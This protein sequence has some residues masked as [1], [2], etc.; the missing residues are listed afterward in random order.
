[1]IYSKIN[2]K[3]ES[4]SCTSCTSCALLFSCC[5]SQE[6]TSSVVSISPKNGSVQTSDDLYTYLKKLRL[7]YGDIILTDDAIEGCNVFFWGKIGILTQIKNPEYN[8]VIVPFLYPSFPCHYFDKIDIYNQV[9]MLFDVV[10]YKSE[11]LKSLRIKDVKDWDENIFYIKSSY[12]YKMKKQHLIFASSDPD[13]FLKK[14]GIDEYLD[15]IKTFITNI[16]SPL[17]VF[18]IDTTNDIHLRVNRK[19]HLLSLYC[20]DC[21]V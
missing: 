12:R 18:T 9:S 2:L 14:K 11:L 10:A 13:I 7:K 21:V 16:T 6:Q 15:V 17:L 20:S 19:T 4:S 1:M 5:P 3:M 8:G